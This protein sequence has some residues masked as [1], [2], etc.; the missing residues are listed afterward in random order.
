M[1]DETK[2]SYSEWKIMELFWTESM[3]TIGEIKERLKDSDW[4]ESTIK[5]LVRRLVDKN[6]IARSG[7]SGKYIF[8]PLVT[9][10][11]CVKSELDS[12]INSVF[13][14]SVYN[15][16]NAIYTG[17]YLDEAQKRKFKEMF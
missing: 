13:N 5:T 6:V 8:F 2:I 12:I 3:L 1:S 15:L 11:E 17:D 10:E 14:G 9:K 7:V 4:S 16:L